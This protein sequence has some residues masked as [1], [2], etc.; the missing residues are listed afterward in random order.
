[1]NNTPT[2]QDGFTAVELIITLIIASMFLFAGY[3]LYTQV[4]RDG[5]DANKT[6]MLSNIVYEK[7]R[8]ESAET[9]DDFPS[10]CIVG[11]TPA[12]SE[13]TAVVTTENVAGIG[14]VSY[15]LDV[16]CVNSSAGVLDV[17]KVK[18]KASY[19]DA[20]VTKEVEHATFVN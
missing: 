7:L 2:Y 5:T 20:G 17:F 4:T 1:M 12:G 8:K 13:K 14:T 10:G 3:Q 9:S 16:A 6:A 11:Q 19:S 18:V 15:Q